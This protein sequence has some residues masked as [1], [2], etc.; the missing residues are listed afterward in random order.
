LIFVEIYFF[1]NA[2]VRVPLNWTKR[3]ILIL[4]I[5]FVAIALPAAQGSRSDPDVTPLPI[6]SD[7]YFLGLY[8]MYKYLEPVVA[9]YITMVIPVSVILC[10]F[11]DTW[12]ITGPRKTS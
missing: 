11:L 3:S 12:I 6:L 4:M 2:Y 9:T 5:A 10:P 7:W 1:K 8:Q